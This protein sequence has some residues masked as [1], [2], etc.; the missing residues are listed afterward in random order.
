MSKQSTI[1]F[2]GFGEAAA[3]FVAGWGSERARRVRAYDI[4]SDHPAALVREGK[5][6]DYRQAGVTGCDDVGA[7]LDGAALVFS[8]VTADQ[9]LAAAQSAVGRIA[10]EALYL[11]CNSCAPGTKRQAAALINAAGGRYV[12]VA[13][14]AP[15][16]PALHRTPLLIAGAAAAD[17]LAALDSLEMNAKP[18]AGEVGAASSIKMIRSVMIKGLEALV[19]ECV[20][21]GRRAGVDATVL[22]TLEASFPGFDWGK[23]AAYMLERVMTHGVR[24]AAEMREVAL[25]VEQLG[26]EADMASATVQWQQRI[27]DLRLA[28]AG[29][30]YRQLADH[31]NTALDAAG[32]RESDSDAAK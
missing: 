1:A 20:L 18:V 16:H 24:R 2:I 3:A 10:P 15:V 28:A 17:A 11:D 5:L 27:G 7:A 21:A 31:I 23:R 19:A 14:M 26:L 29:D 25:T 22:E 30:D 9:A 13:V 4:K 6:A 12:D 8:T 32:Q